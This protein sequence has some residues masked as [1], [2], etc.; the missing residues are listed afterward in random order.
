MGKDPHVEYY[1]VQQRYSGFA[2]LHAHVSKYF[3]NIPPMPPKSLFFRRRFSETF[4][5]NR[6]A[7]LED[8]LTAVL[9]ADPYAA[10]WMLRNFLGLASIEIPR[11]YLGR[12]WRRDLVR[13]RT[14]SSINSRASTEFNE[15]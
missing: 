8:V 11:D 13:T 12:S 2:E 9:K 4:R 3:S 10:T 5:A 1:R 7:M 6:H 15:S 14:N